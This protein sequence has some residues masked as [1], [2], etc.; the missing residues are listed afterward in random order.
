MSN[1]RETVAKERKK[2]SL[3]HHESYINT[4]LLYSSSQLNCILCTQ[5][6]P[7]SSVRQLFSVKNIMYRDRVVDIE[8][9]AVT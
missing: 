8:N 6:S 9:I 1:P 5:I 3:I 7:I 4:L 2:F